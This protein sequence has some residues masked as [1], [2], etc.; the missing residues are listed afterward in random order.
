ML[1]SGG[2]LA[3]K[4]AFVAITALLLL[5][6]LEREASDG[7]KTTRNGPTYEVT[8]LDVVIVGPLELSPGLGEPAPHHPAATR[9]Y[10][11]P[12]QYSDRFPIL[13]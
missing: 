10:L 6:H 13:A 4:T 12:F 2:F 7:F 11:R 3:E 5:R 1:G 8:H 9:L